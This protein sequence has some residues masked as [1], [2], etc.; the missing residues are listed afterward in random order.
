[1]LTI[2]QRKQFFPAMNAAWVI[3][4]DRIGYD[5][6]DEIAQDLW[7]RGEMEDECGVRSIKDLD[8]VYGYER[9]MLRWAETSGNDRSIAYFSS[10]IERRYRWLIGQWLIE[11]GRIEQQH[12]TWSYVVS[13]LAHMHFPDRLED[14]TAEMLR[15]AFFAL[16]THVRRILA[17]R[18]E[19]EPKW[20]NAQLGSKRR[21][22]EWRASHPHAA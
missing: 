15:S 20:W 13:I 6:E 5:A 4:A 7:Y 9:V 10:C 1:M 12:V 11:L 14:L 21:E 18:G 19:H 8:H 16:D 17:A 22:R 2:E 3:A